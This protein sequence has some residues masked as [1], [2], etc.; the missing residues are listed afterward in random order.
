MTIPS[1]SWICLQTPNPWCMITL[2]I[3]L[4]EFVR[5]I[6]AIFHVLLTAPSSQC[7]AYELTE[8]M[9]C[10]ATFLLSFKQHTDHVLGDVWNGFV[11]TFAPVDSLSRVEVDGSSYAVGLLGDTTRWRFGRWN[12]TVSAP[13]VP[14]WAPPRKTPAASHNALS[15]RMH[16]RLFY[17]L[18][19]FENESCTTAAHLSSAFQHNRSGQQTITRYR[20]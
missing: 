17:A 14:T 10:V 2:L 5:D 19:L 6:E 9:Y 11:F 18:Y 16:Y 4:S 20:C 15:C 7:R 8:C 12:Q 1:T 3:I 13:A